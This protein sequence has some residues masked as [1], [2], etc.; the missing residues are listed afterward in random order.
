MTEMLKYTLTI[1][2]TYRAD[3]KHETVILGFTESYR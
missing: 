1:Y 2:Y 3:G